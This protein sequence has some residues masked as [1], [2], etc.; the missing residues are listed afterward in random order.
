M[1][2]HRSQRVRHEYDKKAPISTNSPPIFTQTRNQKKIIQNFDCNK[3][4]H[5]MF[6]L[7]FTHRDE[8]YARAHKLSRTV[9]PAFF[10]RFFNLRRHT[11][12]INR[13]VSLSYVHCLLFIRRRYREI[14]NLNRLPSLVDRSRIFFKK[15]N[16][17]Y[18]CIFS[19]NFFLFKP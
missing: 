15:Y 1:Y 17:L 12:H 14:L 5:I 16:K 10:K 3:R 11:K 8:F 18:P 19:Y 13:I 7:H 9:S 6:N 2:G 4:K